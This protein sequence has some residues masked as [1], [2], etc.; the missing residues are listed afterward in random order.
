MA[1]DAPAR[2][3]DAPT[4]PMGAD[5]DQRE[6]PRDV[7]AARG[8]VARPD[9]PHPGHAYRYYRLGDGRADRVAGHSA[10]ENPPGHKGR[11]RHAAAPPR[12]APSGASD[13][14][15]APFGYPRGGSRLHLLRARGTAGA[16]PDA[17]TPTPSCPPRHSAG[18]LQRSGSIT[19]MQT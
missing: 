5:G 14:H 15:V 17:L 16:Y 6:D 7:S 9:A 8:G 11:H 19:P 18:R 2:G 4:I 3:P 1:G 12:S 10:N 13:D